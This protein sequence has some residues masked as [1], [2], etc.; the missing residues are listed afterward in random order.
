MFHLFPFAAIVLQ[1]EAS[2]SFPWWGWLIIVLVFAVL[3]WLL[4]YTQQSGSTPP[5]ARDQQPPAP[6]AKMAEPA[7]A[8]P[9]AP[10]PAPP[11]PEPEA[12]PEPV[13]SEPEPTPAEPEPAPA[14]PDD[15]TIIEGIGPKIA[16]VLKDAGLSTFAQLA[17]ATPTELKRITD[18]A[19][20]R[21]AFPESWPGQA[22][23]AA[24]GKWTELEAMQ[25]N[26]KA[27]RA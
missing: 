22:A 7:V 16:A 5:A 9:V 15:L 20:I 14:K 3:F 27:G 13:M 11:M 25:N 26:L 6:S 2:N 24:E 18:D 4:A 1:E 19:G 23:L 17:A 21:L 12:E 10:E 8:A